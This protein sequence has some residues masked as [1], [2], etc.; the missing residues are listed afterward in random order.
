MGIAINNECE[1]EVSRKEGEGFK[2]IK[3]LEKSFV[4]LKILIKVI[5]FHVDFNLF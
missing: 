2:Q 5:S 3:S 1:L 4:S